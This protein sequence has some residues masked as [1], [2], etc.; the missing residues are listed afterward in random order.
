M[1]GKMIGGAPYASNRDGLFGQDPL[2]NGGMGNAINKPQ[3]MM[4]AQPEQKK[5]GGDLMSMISPLG[6]LLM[7]GGG[8]GGVGGGNLPMLLGGLLPG[9]L[10]KGSANGSI[11]G[12]LGLVGNQ[13][14]NGQ[15]AQGQGAT[16]LNELFTGGQGA[17]NAGMRQTPD[18]MPM[19]YYVRR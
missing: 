7:G 1:F 16:M 6:S 5:G 10:S 2:A 19:G 9:L 17:N 4:A 18:G 3:E 8:G 13:A 11:A 15:G 14:A 12:L